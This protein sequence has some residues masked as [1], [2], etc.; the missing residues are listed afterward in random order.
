MQKLFTI[1]DPKNFLKMIFGV[2]NTKTFNVFNEIIYACRL[3]DL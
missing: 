3:C 1:D 2:I